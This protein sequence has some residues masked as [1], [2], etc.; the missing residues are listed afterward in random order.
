VLGG[1]RRP[2]MDLAFAEKRDGHPKFS[3][4]VVRRKQRRLSFS[5]QS[6][7]PQGSTARRLRSGAHTRRSLRP[8]S[9]VCQPNTELDGR[10]PTRNSREMRRAN[11]T[12]PG[13]EVNCPRRRD[14]NLD[15]SNACHILADSILDLTR[16]KPERPEGEARLATTR[17][18]RCCGRRP[19]DQAQIHTGNQAGATARVLGAVANRGRYSSPLVRK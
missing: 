4:Q 5:S 19:S 13:T 2:E 16:R 17:V 12:A 18:Q 10:P 6:P 14:Q 15:R 1:F 7:T 11:A 8:A 9:P 3:S